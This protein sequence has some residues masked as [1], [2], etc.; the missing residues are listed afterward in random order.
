MLP[1]AAQL[2]GSGLRV[3]GVLGR[4]RA[5]A[6]IRFLGGPGGFACVNSKSHA[7]NPAADAAARPACSAIATTPMTWWRRFCRTRGEKRHGVHSRCHERRAQY[8][9]RP[10]QAV[11]SHGAHAEGTL[12]YTTSPAHTLHGALAGPDRAATAGNRGF[13]RTRTCPA[14]SRRWRRRMSWSL[15]KSKRFGAPAPALSARHRHGG[16][17]AAEGY[18]GEIVTTAWTRRFHS[19]SATY[20]HPATEAL[21]AT[22]AGTEHDA[23]VCGYPEAGTHRRVLPRGAQKYR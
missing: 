23:P 22:L 11:R 5:D 13:H 7:Q 19:M 18:R 10:L 3:A 9:S 17:G 21:V 8:E 4:C 16:D 2:D 20:G 6:C 15:A 12:S 1:I 14:F